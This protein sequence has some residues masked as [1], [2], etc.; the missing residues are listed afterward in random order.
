MAFQVHTL[1]C[2]TLNKIAWPL[3]WYYWYDLWYWK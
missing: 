2:T 1:K 3:C